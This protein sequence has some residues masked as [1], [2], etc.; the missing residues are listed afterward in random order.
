METTQEHSKVFWKN[1]GSI[2]SLNNCMAAYLSSQKPC[3]LDE[4]DMRDTAGE[5][6]T[7]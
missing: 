1:P 7:N 6:R 2:T 3:Q 5:A 4:Q